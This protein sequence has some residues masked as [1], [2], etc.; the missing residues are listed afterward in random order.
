MEQVFGKTLIC[1]SLEVCGAFTRSYGLNT[2]TLDGDKYDRKGS[3]TGGF[4]DSNRSRLDAVKGFKTWQRQFAEEDVHRREIKTKVAELGQKITQLAGQKQIATS[5]RQKAADERDPLAD[6][7]LALQSEETRAAARVAQLETA[8]RDSE[9]NSRTLELEISGLEQERKTKMQQSLSAA[10]SAELERLQAEVDETKKQLAALSGEVAKLA[11]TKS[12]LELELNENLRRRR[13]ELKSKLDS[14]E[15]SEAAAP[16][17]DVAIRKKEVKQLTTV[18][19]QLAGRLDELDSEMD[20]CR[21]EIVELEAAK[22]KK[23]SQQ[24]EETRSI[25]RQQ[26]SVERYLAK[27]QLL[28]ARKDECNKN[29]RDLGVLP[30]EAFEENRLSSEKVRALLPLSHI[31]KLLTIRS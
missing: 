31:C 7:A 17:E 28:V 4:H 5:K 24:S 1:Q 23:E 12:L 18:I 8:L 30:E 9:A 10:E 26:K 11:S 22:E 16:V 21:K 6:Q 2:I 29:I 14:A 20:D 3:L 15:T 19:E 25:D 27:R 13:D